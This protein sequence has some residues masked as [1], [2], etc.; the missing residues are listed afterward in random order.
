V[1][2]GIAQEIPT[3]SIIESR[4]AVRYKNRC[5]YIP[6]PSWTLFHLIFKTYW[7]GVHDYGIGAHQYAD[8]CRVAPALDE[9]EIAHLRELIERW[10]MEAGA[11][12]VLRRL[13]SEFG[14]EPSPAMAAYLDDISKPKQ[15]MRPHNNNDRGD[16][17]PK[18]WGN[19]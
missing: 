15:G 10:H 1:H 4:R 16:M 5:W 11:W 6:R 12:F 19:F 3:T 13:P 9:S 18:L 8:I 14:I 2:H 7:E 17:W